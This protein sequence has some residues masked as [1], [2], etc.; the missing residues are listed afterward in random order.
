MKDWDQN[1]KQKTGT[2][3]RVMWMGDEMLG[4][5]EDTCAYLGVM[6]EDIDVLLWKQA[7]RK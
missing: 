6:R 3:V 1:N 5:E 4:A 7:I 2:G